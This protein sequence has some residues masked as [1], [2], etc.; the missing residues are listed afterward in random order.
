MAERYN[1]NTGLKEFVLYFEDRDEEARIYFNPSDENLAV[2]FSEMQD[3]VNEKLKNLTDIE[4]DEN[5]MP[6]DL[7]FVENIKEIET[8]IRDEIDRAFG[9]KISDTV[10]KYCHPMAITK[11]DYFVV[12]FM[13]AISPAIEKIN[14]ET[15]KKMNKHLEK[16]RK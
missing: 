9:N 11:G 16:Y 4:L 1:L 13:K 2:R 14:K 5:G 8:L 12:Q 10:F 7:G 15:S 6:K 3:R